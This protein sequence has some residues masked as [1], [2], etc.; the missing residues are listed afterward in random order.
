MKMKINEFQT[1]AWCK[2]EHRLKRICGRPSPMKRLV[3]VLVIGVVLAFVNVWFLISS[4]YNIGKNDAEKELMNL[5]HI[6]RLELQK[7]KEE[8][9]ECE[10]FK[11]FKK[12]NENKE[13]D[14]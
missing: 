7:K 12:L 5:Q 4:I 2:I 6:E 3:T 8:C 9:K 13:Y 11:E 14:E 10:E 1:K